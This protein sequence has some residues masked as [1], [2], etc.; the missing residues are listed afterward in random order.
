MIVRVRYQNKIRLLEKYLDKVNDIENDSEE[1]Y[2]FAKSLDEL[3]TDNGILV[4]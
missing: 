2:Y 1:I 3:K 4:K